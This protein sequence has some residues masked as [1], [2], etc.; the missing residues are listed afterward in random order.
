MS[1][2]EVES[3]LDHL[4]DLGIVESTS[5]NALDYY[6]DQVVPTLGRY[7]QH[8]TQ[9]RSAVLVGDQ[10]LTS[11]I[12]RYLNLSLPELDLLVP[13]PDAWRLPARETNDALHLGNSLA[14]QKLLTRYEDWRGR[15]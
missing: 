6:L 1:R 11:E 5:S 10:T 2:E 14:F 8:S 13:E 15:F 12:Q 9:E 4:I 3:L 7:A